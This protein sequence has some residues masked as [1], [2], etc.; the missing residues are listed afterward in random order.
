MSKSKGN[1]VD[2]LDV[3]SLLGAD[4]L[5]F[6]MATMATETQD[7]RMPVEFQ[8]PTCTARI[9]QTTQNRTKPRIFCPKCNQAFRTQ[10]ATDEADLALPRGAAVSE[11]FEAGRNFSN[12]LWNA[13]RFVLMNLQDSGLSASP[14]KL[15]NITEFPLED[16]WLLSRLSTVSAAVSN[17]IEH[18]HFAETARLLYAFAWDEFCSAYL[19]LCKPRL[20]D[21]SQK[22]QACHMLLLGL[23]TILRLLHP[24]MPFV[25]EEIWQNLAQDHGDRSYPWDTKTIPPSIM[26]ATWPRPPENW[27]DHATEKQFQTFLE[28]V[29][30]IRE[31]RS[32]QNV[33]P[34]KSVDVTVCPPT[35]NQAMLIPMQSA[36]EAM[37][38]CRVVG[39]ASDAH[40]APGSAEI[41]AADCD[42]FI[43]LADL[44]D[45]DAEIMRLQRELD[46]LEKVIKAKQVKLNN[47]K[48]V[49]HAPPA[50]V[51]KERQQ[52]AEFEETRT[53]QGVIL[54][55]L[56]ARKL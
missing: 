29:G 28:I 20:N 8:C 48:F 34:R 11:R 43:D 38:V 53:K 50:I 31:I 36:I 37:A 4:A 55:D 18:Y 56:Q 26:V 25:T 2:P 44:I 13:T 33:P 52:L 5:R 19:E 42:I 40:P 30:A 21:P 1:G 14:P 24:I 49:S 12:K 27:Q 39:L 9:D 35:H 54:T 22:G 17:N 46:K 51:E 41:S 15:D 7:V 23:D 6:G 10:W 32:R 45:I 3:I 16:R 47:Q